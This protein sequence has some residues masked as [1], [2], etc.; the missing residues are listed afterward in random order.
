MEE[1]I[2]K[3]VLVMLKYRSNSSCAEYSELQR[4]TDAIQKRFDDILSR[5]VYPSEEQRLGQCVF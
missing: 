1:V 3:V 4:F 5:D 2:E